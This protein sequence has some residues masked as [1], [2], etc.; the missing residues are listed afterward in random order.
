[1]SNLKRKIS[2]L[3]SSAETDTDNNNRGKKNIKRSRLLSD[4]HIN[5]EYI[6]EEDDDIDIN[7]LQEL[8]V[9]SEDKEHQDK[10][11]FDINHIPMSFDLSKWKDMNSFDQA[12]YSK[13][14]ESKMTETEY[15]QAYQMRRPSIPSIPSI[16]SASISSTPSISILTQKDFNIQYLIRQEYGAINMIN[17]YEDHDGTEGKEMKDQLEDASGPRRN[18]RSNSQSHYHYQS[19]QTQEFIARQATLSSIAKKK[20]KIKWKHLKPSLSQYQLNKYLNEMKKQ[21]TTTEIN[22]QVIFFWHDLGKLFHYKKKN[23]T[24]NNNPDINNQSHSQALITPVPGDAG[25]YSYMAMREVNYI[26]HLKELKNHSNNVDRNRSK[27]DYTDD[28]N[29]SRTMGHEYFLRPFEPIQNDEKLIIFRLSF[30][31]MMHYFIQNDLNEPILENANG[32]TYYQAMEPLRESCCIRIDNQHYSNIGEHNKKSDEKYK[33]KFKRPGQNNDIV[34]GPRVITHPTHVPHFIYKG[35]MS[36][37]SK[38]ELDAESSF[39]QNDKYQK[40]LQHVADVEADMQKEMARRPL[41]NIKKEKEKDKKDNNDIEDRRDAIMMN[42]LNKIA[43]LNT[44][45][46]TQMTNV[47]PTM[48]TTKVY[49]LMD[50]TKPLQLIPTPPRLVQMM[51]QDQ[52]QYQDTKSSELP[53][54]QINENTN[55]TSILPFGSSTQQQQFNKVD[56]MINICSL[57]RLPGHTS[58]DCII[59]R[60]K[61][62]NSMNINDRAQDIDI[63]GYDDDE[64][65]IPSDRYLCRLCQIPG[66]YINDCPRKLAAYICKLCNIPG[67]KLEDCEQFVKKHNNGNNGN[68]Y[69]CKLCHIP[70]HKLEECELFVKKQQT[71]NFG[72]SINNNNYVCKLCHIPGHKL[73]ECKQFVKKSKYI[74]RLCNNQGHNIKDCPQF[75]HKINNNN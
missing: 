60:N 74:C 33:K 37:S 20:N 52:D 61:N 18:S 22:K 65:K 28:I 13:C 72:T 11:K 4:V 40:N 59:T 9:E 24:H 25:R 54:N 63:D 16:P 19:I 73:E 53:T 55:N 49:N 46:S 45:I 26:K 44:K 67:H 56:G 1:M 3:S 34:R 41:V 2:S 69:I 68:V 38:E 7:S 36:S 71:T 30:H 50:A 51:N 6:N 17:D 10:R 8:Q 58:Q 64:K 42:Y 35:V 5:E 62:M 43:I 14:H 57:C 31:Q 15:L 75:V 47:R 32:Q 23:N 21:S 48:T 70:G 27:G 29:E 39:W 12:F 66:H